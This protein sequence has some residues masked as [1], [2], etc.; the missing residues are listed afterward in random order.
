MTLANGFRRAGRDV[1]LALAF[2]CLVAIAVLVK[3]VVKELRFLSSADSDNVH[4]TLSQAEV[5]FL[6]FR[7][8]VNW[9][10]TVPETPLSTVIVEFDVFYSRTSTLANGSQYSPLREDPAFDAP[11]VEV[12]DRL[13]AMIPLIDGPREDLRAGL[14]DLAA[15]IE[16]MR[17]LVRS[18]ATTGLQHFA[19]ESDE[20]RTSLATTLLRLAVFT[21]LLLLALAALLMHAYRTAQQT[22]KRGKELAIAYARLN[23]ILNTSLDAVVVTDTEGR[24]QNF[25]PAAERIFGRRLKDVRNKHIGDIIVP[26]HLREAHDQ[27]MAR[28]AADGERRVIGQGRVKLEGMRANGEVFPVELAIET[29]HAGEEQL[30]VAFLRD[31]SHRVASENELVQARD[32]ALAGEQAKAEFLAMMTHEIRTPLNGILGNLSLMEDTKLSSDQARYM[33]N[34]KISGELLMRHVDAV[35]DVARFE[36]G[37]DTAQEDVTHLGHLMQD[38]VDSQTSAAHAHG[39]ALQ[40]SWVGT[41][42]EWVEVDSSRLQQILLNLVGNAIKFTREG[43]ISIEAEVIEPGEPSQIEIRV[44]DTGSG[45]AEGDLARIFED[46]QTVSHQVSDSVGGTGLGL[47]IVRRFV[48][49]MGGEIGVES[50]LGEGSTFWLRIPVMPAEEPSE[51]KGALPESEAPSDLEILLVEDNDINMQLAYEVL[52]GMGHHVT[53]ARD[54]QEA[55]DVATRRPFD[56]VLMD[57]RMPV[58]DGLTATK[59]IREGDGPNWDAPIVAFSANVLP[60]A[61]DR[62]AAAGMSD[63]L[64]KPLQRSELAQIIVRFCAGRERRV[65]LDGTTPLLVKKKESPM[66][67]LRARYISET[68][69]LFEWLA[70]L[71]ED[72]QAIA[73]RA[74]QIAGSAAAFGQPGVREALLLVEQVAESGD[75]DDLVI[76]INE[77][78]AAWKAAPEPSLIS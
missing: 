7:N 46:F 47:G 17:A 75:R 22:D 19:L 36:S 54:G 71:P 78:Q 26:E 10:R 29:A 63:F 37:A 5:E 38:L 6:E 52:V 14:D 39:N 20:L 16:D 74:H 30:L 28:F 45:I 4:W 66:E 68:S 60:E 44:S 43:R 58:M 24:V 48:Q 15:Q 32:K 59:M 13:N 70:G 67:K 23:T 3:D 40:W 76:A 53:E 2:L 73:N 25:N 12:R 34:M 65:T 55:V 8:A 41:P 56:L 57:I 27:G 62:F 61:R 69:A 50:T 35:L 72:T 11:L 1:L 9:A 51:D 31:I 49:A 33:R 21:G 77:A 18:I 42:E 64:G